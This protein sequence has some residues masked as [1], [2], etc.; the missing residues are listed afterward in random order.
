MKNIYLD[1]QP[2]WSKKTGIGWYTYKITES[3]VKNKKNNYIGGVFNPFGIRKIEKVT[4]LKYREIKYFWPYYNYGGIF[5]K[6]IFKWKFISFNKI[7]NT[8]FDVYHFFN[9][10]IPK[11]I[12]GKVVT[13]IHDTIHKEVREGIDFDIDNFDEE[14]IHSLEKSDIIITVSNSAKQD[15]IKYYG[16]KY[17]KKLRVVEP[18]V[19]LGE[20]NKA[21]NLEEKNE[22]LKKFKD[23]KEKEIL[24]SIG[25][26][27]K[28]KN[29][30]NII[31][32]YNL[33]RN[34]NP[35]SKLVL[36]I[37][38]NPGRGYEEIIKEY[39]TSK[40]K[41][42]IK[43]LHYISEKEKILLYKISKIFIFPSLYE[44]FG[45][46]IVEAM[47]AGVPVITSNVSSMPEVAGS[48]ALIINPYSVEEVSSAIEK[49][50][51]D[52]GLREEKIKLGYIQCQKYTWE[53]SS[54]K[55]EKIYEEI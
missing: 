37:A 40:Y 43:I 13:T 27:Q 20:Y 26:L 41:E 5:S 42:N 2:T 12:K 8:K 15:I 4:G 3:L 7:T 11:K 52:E 18:G 54:K 33:Y 6:K 30:V 14:I 39:E 25:T 9:F 49:Y 23:L 29:I 36:I 46:P 28:R 10:T 51:L 38:G 35:K 44:G 31:K 48:A 45:M 16:K 24:F 50:D 22:I 55:L 34:K 21:I 47:A 32:A 17:S 53:N 1:M 19:N